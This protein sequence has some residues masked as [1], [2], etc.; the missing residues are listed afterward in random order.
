MEDIKLVIAG[1]DNA[2]KTSF[3][4]ALRQKYNFHEIVKNLKPTI[5][6]DYNSFNFLNHWT[7]NLWDMGGQAKYR[8]IYINNT[9][10]F[11]ETNYLY[12]FIDI[13]D[14]LKFEES[15]SYLYELLNIYRDMEY[16]N[17]IIICFHKYDPKFK[18]NEDFSERVKM[19]KKLIL[20][21]N[22]DMQFQFFETSFY[23]I[24]SLSKA[25]S[26]SLNK[27][28][29]LGAI[30]SKLESIVKD[31][32]CNFVILYTDAGLIISDSYKESMDTMDPR[33]FQEIISSKISDNLEF[34][35][36]LAD[37]EV[38][39]DERLTLHSDTMEYV[40]KYNVEFEE[41]I[42]VFYLSISV[43]LDKIKE[44]KAELEK[45]QNL[46]KFTFT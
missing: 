26:Y 39:I 4:I 6:I 28:L 42:N 33:D 29:N 12:Y 40:K 45:I 36:R 19:I 18:K 10:Y 5:K 37:N 35:Q 9:I 31:F 17:E 32:N 7:I 25:I 2:G 34:F 15:I 14:E 41:R 43:P 11:A 23:D 20:N 3:L 27:L 21:K 30:N 38:N 22:N 24:S 13:Q 8:T 44:M 16:S 1:L 46:L